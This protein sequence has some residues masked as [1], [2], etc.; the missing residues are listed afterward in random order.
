MRA[1]LHANAAVV[2]G[3]EALTTQFDVYLGL[4]FCLHLS[5]AAEEVAQV[6]QTKDVGVKPPR[7]CTEARSLK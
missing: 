1:S 5:S 2:C 7:S 3:S 6:P 4:K